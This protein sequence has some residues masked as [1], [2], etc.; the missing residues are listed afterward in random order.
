[1]ADEKLIGMY[2]FHRPYRKPKPPEELREIRAE[3]GRRVRSKR[4]ARKQ[5]HKIMTSR[6]V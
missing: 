4:Q 1:M 5:G 6:L 2:T 3:Q